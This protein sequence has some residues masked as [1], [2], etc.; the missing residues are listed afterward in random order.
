MSSSSAAA[1]GIRF[2]PFPP[3]VLYFLCSRSLACTLLFSSAWTLT[4]RLILNT[5]LTILPFFLFI[6]LMWERKNFAQFTFQAAVSPFLVL[7]QSQLL[8]I[9]LSSKNAPV[10][11]SSTTVVFV[12]S[13]LLGFMCNCVRF[14]LLSVCIGL[15]V[16]GD[17]GSWESRL[18]LL[19]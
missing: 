15:R 9:L 11:G 16:A 14:V 3:K 7:Q 6:M 2:V 1:H 5:S 18:K 19:S 13:S 8:F 4:Q 17:A 12:P 10:F